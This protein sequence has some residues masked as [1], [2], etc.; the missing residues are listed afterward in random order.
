MSKEETAKKC[1]M[2]KLSKKSN[3]ELISI[4]IRKDDIERRNSKVID[5][6]KQNVLG[7][8]KKVDT[9][10]SD[11]QLVED[12]CSNKI[13]E[14]ISLQT[15]SK[16]YASEMERYKAMYDKELLNNENIKKSFSYIVYLVI[17]LIMVI[18]A[19]IVL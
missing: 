15:Q 9:I 6:L 7:L 1:R 18:V 3:E 16:Q 14:I 19:L 12:E 10:M 5:C 2:T 13:D 17:V 4:I 11:K 8:Q